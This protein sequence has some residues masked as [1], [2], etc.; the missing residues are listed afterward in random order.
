MG[1]NDVTDYLFSDDHDPL[2]RAKAALAYFEMHIGPDDV[3][4]DPSLLDAHRELVAE[5]ERLERPND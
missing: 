4:R 1:A 2:A 5:V 3:A